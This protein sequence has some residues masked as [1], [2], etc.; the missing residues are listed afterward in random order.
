VITVVG[1]AIIDLVGDHDGITFHA[2][3]GGS[4]YNVAIA[5][6]RLGAP[7]RL[8]ARL[9]HDRF[10][11]LLRTHAAASGVDLSAAVSADEPSTLAVTCV[12]EH[13]AATYDFYV[14]GTADWR[15]REDELD[16]VERSALVHF[17]SLAS[18]MSPGDAVL[19]GAVARARG[20]V[21]Y[22][23]NVRPGLIGTR[24]HARAAI[25]RNVSV[26]DVVK[27]SN[28]DVQWLYPNVA[29]SETAT[30]WLTGRP[31]LV[32]VTGGRHGATAYTSQYEPL[33]RPARTVTVADTVGAGDAWMGSVL[34]NFHTRGATSGESI[35]ALSPTQ[36]A[37]LLDAAMLV[38]S[39]AC[40]RRGADPPTADDVAT[41]SARQFDQ[42]AAAR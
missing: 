22:D 20:L 7:T 16:V 34:A 33:H 24:R 36:I 25:E 28:E 3:P 13:G 1:E 18:W 12:D 11:A 30:R 42:P 2:R 32:L 29:P 27:A 23:P 41:A 10:G 21:T 9:A 5:T 14:E 15:W 26:A 35:L 40:V 37:D 19:H 8:L 17:G 6:A 31:S 38:A 39:L 4:P